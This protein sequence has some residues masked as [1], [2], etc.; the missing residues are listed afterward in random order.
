[1]LICL[2]CALDFGQGNNMQ[3]MESLHFLYITFAQLPSEKSTGPRELNW[4]YI[5]LLKSLNF[6][7]IP[8]AKLDGHRDTWTGCKKSVPTSFVLSFI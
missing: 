6:V 2:P 4:F 5:F 8:G 7:F 1:M 3:I